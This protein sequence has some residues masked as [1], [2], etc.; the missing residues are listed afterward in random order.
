MALNTD[1]IT[2]QQVSGGLSNPDPAFYSIYYDGFWLTGKISRV[3]Q[4][5]AGRPKIRVKLAVS[6]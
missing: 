6:N 2:L 4:P 3:F 5:I 1:L